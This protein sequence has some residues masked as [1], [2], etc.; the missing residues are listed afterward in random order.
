M[1]LKPRFLKQ[2]QRIDAQI[3]SAHHDFDFH[4]SKLQQ[5]FGI[6][7]AHFDYDYDNWTDDDLNYDEAISELGYEYEYDFR[8]L[9]AQKATILLFAYNIA[10]RGKRLHESVVLKKTRKLGA[11]GE[12]I[13]KQMQDFCAPQM[14]LCAQPHLH[15]ALHR[16]KVLLLDSNNYRMLNDIVENIER[17]NLPRHIK[18]RRIENCAKIM[19][20]HNAQIRKKYENRQKT[21]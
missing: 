8:R 19:K 4:K 14:L 1:K 2:I 17:S 7:D 13:R 12:F 9:N 16:N 21:K 10:R 5:M 20:L 11:D 18:M 6:T 3:A 15:A